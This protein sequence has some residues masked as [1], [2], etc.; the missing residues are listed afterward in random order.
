M[1]RGSVGQHRLT[2]VYRF[3]SAEGRHATIEVKS[4]RVVA[5]QVEIVAYLA[6]ELRNR[7][8]TFFAVWL[9]SPEILA[10]KSP[11]VGVTLE[12]GVIDTERIAAV[13]GVA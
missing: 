12:N 6:R 9:V 2:P 8:T 10:A 1:E 11:C 7:D 13:A 4:L 5:Q 3:I